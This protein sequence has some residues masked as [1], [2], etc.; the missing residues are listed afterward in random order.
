M[1]YFKYLNKNIY[2]EI[3]GTGKPVIILNGIMM[4]TRSWDVFTD[5]FSAEFMFIRV[6]F[7]DQ[8]RTDSFSESYDLG[9]QVEL[10]K[11]LIEVLKLEKVNL[12]GISYGG[13][14]ALSFAIKYQSLVERMIVFNTVSHTNK[15]LAET[16]HLWNYHAKLRNYEKYYDLTIPVIYSD[17][18]INENHEWMKKREGLLLNGPFKDHGFLDRMIRL[19]D[20]AEFY[21]VREELSKLFIPVL[22]VG[23]EEDK[24]TPL[25]EQRLLKSLIPGSKLIIFPGVGHAS[26]YEVP[27]LFVSV[28]IGYFK[29]HKIDYKI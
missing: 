11:E 26:M 5:S 24:L 16:G 13:E 1:A 3:S 12:V 20:S 4:S 18:F 21:D 14:V 29:P 23:A 6:D 15:K 10:L 25:F 27:E 17:D 2:Y 7:I 22:I 9:M 8:G 28:V 19:T